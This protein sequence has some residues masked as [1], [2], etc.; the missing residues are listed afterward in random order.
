MLK[1]MSLLLILGVVGCGKKSSSSK[2]TTSGSQLEEKQLEVTQRETVNFHRKEQM[3]SR[4]DCDQNITSRKLETLNG[5]SKKLTINYEFRKNAWNYSVYNRTTKEKKKG[6]LKVDG[7]FT[8]DYAPTLFNMR[9]K[10]GIN[11]IEYA[12]YT[13]TDIS[14]DPKAPGGLKCNK[15]LEIEK[16][17]IVQV[18]VYYSSEVV[19]GERHIYMPKE[20]CKKP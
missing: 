20:A 4:Y 18:D 17:G 11:D 9:V 7:N 12:F 19:P 15:E 13:C 5:L 1:L 3:T 14:V 2:N 16:E 10:Q 6:F 8:I